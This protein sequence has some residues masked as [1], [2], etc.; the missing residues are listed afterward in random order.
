MI[1]Y[2]N[3]H[4]DNFVYNG[5][6]SE[7]DVARKLLSLVSDMRDICYN[8]TKENK[9]QCHVDIFS[10][11]IYKNNNI[12]DFAANHLNNDE[13]GVFFSVFGNTSNS[14]KCSL[15]ELKDKCRYEVDEKEV[16]CM[17][18]LNTLSIDNPVSPSQFDEYEVIFNHQ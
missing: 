4:P 9:F 14:F 8:K 6:D 10:C 13:Q 16:N 12:I 5:I 17:L 1:A 7:P 15:E 3:I 18:L 11:L 2:L